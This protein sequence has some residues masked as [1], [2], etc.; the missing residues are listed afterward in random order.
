MIIDEQTG[1]RYNLI[2]GGNRSAFCSAEAEVLHYHLPFW[3]NLCLAPSVQQ[4]PL[5]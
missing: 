3:D 5:A 2:L 1:R 4:I